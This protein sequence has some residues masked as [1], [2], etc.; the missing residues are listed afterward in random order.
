MSIERISKGA[1]Y[2]SET[3]E[4]TF[5]TTI[6]HDDDG[7][8]MEIFVRIDDK[9]LFEMIQLVTRLTSMLLQTG[10]DPMAMANE[11]Q[12]VY[13]PITR[14][15]IPGTNDMCPSIIARIGL[16]LENHIISRVITEANDA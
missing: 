10:T 13:S 11:L 1:T 3:Q 5:Y 4:H 16:I 15:M 8:V 12:E 14:H 9:N 7:K 2:K 6:N